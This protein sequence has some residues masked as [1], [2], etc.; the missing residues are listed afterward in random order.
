MILMNQTGNDETEKTLLTD[1]LVVPVQAKFSDYKRKTILGL[2]GLLLLVL[3]LGA[4]MYLSQR[5][6]NP[7]TKAYNEG[8]MLP[9]PIAE[10]KFDEGL[11]NKVTDSA[12]NHLG[13]WNGTGTH[14]TDGKFGK[15][16]SFNGTDDSVKVPDAT[17]LH[18]GNF[19]ITAWFKKSSGVGHILGKEYGSGGRDSYVIWFPAGNKIA[20]E[21]NDGRG[22]VEYAQVADGQWYHAAF[23]KSGTGTSLFIDG[24][25]V[26]TASSASITT[27]FDNSSIFI[28]ADDND[29][30]EVADALFN[31]VIDQVRIY[32]Y[33]L[34]GAQVLKDMGETAVPQTTTTISDDFNGASLD[35]GKW[36]TWKSPAGTTAV[37][38]NQENGV[39]RV[40]IPAGQTAY[41]DGVIQW[42]QEIQGDFEVVADMKV[43]QS[44]NKS[45][46]DTLINFH[47]LQDGWK[48]SFMVGL[49]REKDNLHLFANTKA[50]DVW[51]TEFSAALSGNSAKVKL[52]RIGSAINFFYDAGA[53]YVL[54]GS[55]SNIFGGNGRLILITNTWGEFPAVTSTF[56]NFFARVNLAQQPPACPAVQGPAIKDVTGVVQTMAAGSFVWL[57]DDGGTP[58][59]VKVD[60]GNVSW[61]RQFLAGDEPDDIPMTYADLKVGHRIKILGGFYETKG[62]SVIQVDRVRDMNLRMT[63]LK[64]K[65]KTIT[66]D[67]SSFTLAGDKTV[68]V[69]DRAGCRA[70]KE[71]VFSPARCGEIL[72]VGHDVKATGVYEEKTKTMTGP[73]AAG[74]WTKITDS[75]YTTPTPTPTP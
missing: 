7:E 25:Q 65:I 72:A 68:L 18:S 5:Q 37:T 71:T 43:E 60:C 69:K 27:S 63:A 30:N 41:S 44:D 22:Y 40:T 73:A 53:G 50:N 36:D 3:G 49:R 20:A 28:G 70:A 61:V 19:S 51:G 26:S 31:G 29:D 42:K 23:T 16:G 8:P 58:L 21:T 45:A 1:E 54:L 24:I 34:T 39:F 67:K 47:D 62:G 56:D 9:K 6:Q 13:R 14:W 46:A 2:G 15:A 74:T 75:S 35:M 10:W 38:A 4:G 64:G 17:D 11:G 55:R 33:A 52:Q 57:P 66:A 32:D 59:T 48:E 12:G